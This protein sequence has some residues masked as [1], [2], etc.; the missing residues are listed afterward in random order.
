MFARVKYYN[1]PHDLKLSHIHIVP[2]A[3]G[4][5]YVTAELNLRGYVI[6][7][8]GSSPYKKDFYTHE[9][10]FEDDHEDE[11]GKTQDWDIRAALILFPETKEESYLT[12][13]C[14]NIY[15]HTYHAV[16]ISSK[17]FGKSWDRYCNDRLKLNSKKG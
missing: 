14:H 12:M 15:K 2:Q 7:S 9:T 6:G 4:I 17:T 13:T 11:T 3:K 16:L 10:Y 1:K 5:W 8:T